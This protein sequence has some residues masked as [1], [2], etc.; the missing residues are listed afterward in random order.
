[1]RGWIALRHTRGMLQ[2]SIAAVALSRL[3]SL[4]P[5]ATLNDVRFQADGSRL[6]VEFEEE[7]ARV[8]QHG[9]GLIAAPER[10]GGGAAVLADGLKRDMVSA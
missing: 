10:C 7:A 6:A 9:A 5:V 8:A 4:D 3:G 1:M 2:T